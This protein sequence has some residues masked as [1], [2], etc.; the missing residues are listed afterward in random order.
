MRINL[1]AIRGRQDPK[2][3]L[4]T[5]AERLGVATSTIQRWEKGTSTIPNQRLDEVAAA[6]QCRIRDIYDDELEERS[7]VVPLPPPLPSEAALAVVLDVILE[8]T[9]GLTL[10]SAARRPAAAALRLCLQLLRE[11]PAIDAND[12]AIKAVAR[13][14]VVRFPDP[15]PEA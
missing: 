13:A 8:G 7:N 12:D 14:L 3:T 10:P 4:E 1:E 11:N 5:M 2:L 15:R 6:Y 9:A